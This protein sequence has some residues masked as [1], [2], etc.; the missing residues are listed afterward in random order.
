MRLLHSL[1]ALLLAFL[2]AAALEAPSGAPEGSHAA[3]PGLQLAAAEHRGRSSA[4][5]DR[6]VAAAPA[7]R[8]GAEFRYF[9]T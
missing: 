6:V 1:D 3:F 4:D 9:S 5:V 2:D 7:P 8:D